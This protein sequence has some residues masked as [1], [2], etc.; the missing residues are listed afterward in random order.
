MTVKSS[1]NF[2]VFQVGGT[3]GQY[4]LLDRTITRQRKQSRSRIKQYNQAIR[5]PRPYQCSSTETG[6]PEEIGMIDQYI[7]RNRTTDRHRE[8]SS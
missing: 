2:G 6:V 3:T 7:L 4:G 1:D 8:I 5:S